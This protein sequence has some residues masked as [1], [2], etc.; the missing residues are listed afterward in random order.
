MEQVSG[1][2]GQVTSRA[3]GTSCHDCYAVWQ[4]SLKC[5][6]PDF[7]ALAA[8]Y[9]S[10]PTVKDKVDK[11]AAVHRGGVASFS[12]EQ[13]ESMREVKIEVK[14]HYFVASDSELR[15]LLHVPRILK[16]HTKGL[17]CM[18]LPVEGRPNEEETVHVFA[19]P[20]RPL[21]SAEVTMVLGVGA[22]AMEMP[23][24]RSC[25]AG[26]AKH[27]AASWW[28][29]S[30]TQAA[31]LASSKLP[32]LSEYL[33]CHG[34]QAPSAA[35]LQA[36]VG[37][38]GSPPSDADED[39]A[40][41]EPAEQTLIGIA[42]LSGSVHPGAVGATPSPAKHRPPVPAFAAP[43]RQARQA[44]APPAQAGR[45]PSRSNIGSDD[46]DS[47]GQS[48][49]DS[50][51][52]GDGDGS[53]NGDDFDIV[54]AGRRGCPRGGGGSEASKLRLQVVCVVSCVLRR[55]AFHV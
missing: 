52:G 49:D 12:R 29:S 47:V 50:A 23:T 25:Y 38:S 21:R 16:A 48:M 31:S 13:V 55:L 11:A 45:A 28:A 17:G 10:D 40:D 6:F 19:D 20:S 39:S 44:S 41:D 46:D 27:E 54:D 53:E 14:R 22:R 18:T 8:Q 37:A 7:S 43:A 15:S 2:N 30:E 24:S 51:I 36:S 9:G 35:A 32:S 4:D 1:A 42:A 33:T 5:E 26:Q 34:V 3:L